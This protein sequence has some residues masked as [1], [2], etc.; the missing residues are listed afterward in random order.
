MLTRVNIVTIIFITI[1]AVCFIRGLKNRFSGE[2][3]YYSVVGTINTILLFI[4]L[5][6]SY[7][8]TRSL[9]MN[10]WDG[11]VYKK[12]Y[13][14]LPGAAKSFIADGGILIYVVFVPVI[15]AVIFPLLTKLRSMLDNH[16]R[17]MSFGVC[18]SIRRT[19]AVFRWLIG[20]VVEIP[21]ALVTLVTVVLLISLLG[22]YYPANPLT[23][24][25]SESELYNSFYN[26]S[27]S[28]MMN[29]SYGQKVPV[30]LQHSINELS[31]GLIDNKILS[32]SEAFK[33]L[34]NIRFQYETKSNEKIDAMAKKIVG[35]ETDE[36]KKAYLLYKWVGN[37][38]N[39]DWGKYNNVVNKISNSDKFGAIPA[40]ETRQGICEDYSDLYVAMAKAVGL[41]VRIIVGQGYSMGYWGGHAWNEVYIP[42]ENKWI[43]IDATWAKGGDFFDSR[44]FYKTHIIEGVAA[45]W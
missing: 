40:F 26:K 33:S 29:S 12:I 7:G 22:A 38:I 39:Y 27:V 8:I 44:D 5:F 20:V 21:K 9:I 18:N 2:S 24:H 11:Q 23:S 6:I 37:N 36:R 32:D 25:A 14:I 13:D 45:E 34:G 16:L 31:K 1:I 4:S 28:R 17:K 19:N 41:K 35:S 42:K 30:F 3:L 43:P 15:T 10:K